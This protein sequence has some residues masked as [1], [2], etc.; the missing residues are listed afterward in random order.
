MIFHW[1]LFYINIMS[2]TYIYF[3][4]NFNTFLYLYSRLA[5]IVFEA[6]SKQFEYKKVWEATKKL[7]FCFCFVHYEHFW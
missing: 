4:H 2:L 1:V 7:F 5:A 6:K 3:S